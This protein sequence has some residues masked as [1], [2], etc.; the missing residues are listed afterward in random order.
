MVLTNLLT[1]AS[2]CQSWLRVGLRCTRCGSQKGPLVER[3]ELQSLKCPFIDSRHWCYIGQWSLSPLSRPL[4]TV[5][6]W[7]ANAAPINQPFKMRISVSL[8]IKPLPFAAIVFFAI[9]SVTKLPFR[10]TPIT[11]NSS[12]SSSWPAA[13]KANATSVA[14]SPALSGALSLYVRILRPLCMSAFRS[15]LYLL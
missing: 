6:R 13:S 8:L 4:C 5:K 11:A 9:S 10:S 12:A 7:T 3:S 2:E 15:G 14:L 1:L